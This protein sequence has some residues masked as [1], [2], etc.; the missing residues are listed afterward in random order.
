MHHA[1]ITESILRK[2][3]KCCDSIENIHITPA[4][5][6]CK[7]VALI[8]FTRPE[9]CLIATLFDGDS[10][11]RSKIRVEKYKPTESIGDGKVKSTETQEPVQEGNIEYIEVKTEPSDEPPAKKTK[12]NQAEKQK[13]GKIINEIELVI[14]K[15]PIDEAEEVGE[16]DGAATVKGYYKS[17]KCIKFNKIYRKILLTG[18]DLR[19]AVPVFV[20]NLPLNITKKEIKQMFKKFGKVILVCFRA[21][22]GQEFGECTESQ[23]LE[24]P[25]SIAFVHLNTRDAAKASLALNGK[26]VGDKFITVDLDFEDKLANLAPNMKPEN[27]VVVTNLSRCKN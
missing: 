7:G 19:T 20:G 1:E 13:P 9:S 15:E 10:L 4:D 26:K 17:L 5:K 18:S 6:D 11:H 16:T 12:Q 2:K 14:K 22:T 21:N 3:F 25:N 27:T 8:R 23:L 24:M